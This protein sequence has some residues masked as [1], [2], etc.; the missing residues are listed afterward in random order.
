MYHIILFS[1]MLLLIAIVKLIAI[2]SQVY[3]LPMYVIENLK[4]FCVR[5]EI[6]ELARQCM[7]DQH[8][9]DVNQV[10]KDTVKE[11]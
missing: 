4:E 2:V 10:E 5:R 1:S 8:F 9:R 7:T 6:G 11:Q 3:G